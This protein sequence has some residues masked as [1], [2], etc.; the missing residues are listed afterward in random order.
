MVAPG[1]AGGIRLLKDNMFAASPS[2]MVTHRQP[3]LAAPDNDGVYM[4]GGH[5]W[6]LRLRAR[7]AAFVEAALER[8]PG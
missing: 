7:W 4:C 6:S 2:Q 5:F 8:C 1:I 3:G